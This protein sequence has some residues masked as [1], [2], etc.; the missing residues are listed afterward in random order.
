MFQIKR[1]ITDMDVA[2]HRRARLE[3][4]ANVPQCGQTAYRSG[5]THCFD[6][7][8]ELP[9]LVMQE[10]QRDMSGAPEK[11]A[12][13]QF[14]SIQEPFGTPYL[15]NSLF[16]RREYSAAARIYRRLVETT[17]EDQEMLAY[18]LTGL[19]ATLVAQNKL[20]EARE[21]MRNSV[22]AIIRSNG[23]RVK[24]VA[25]YLNV[26]ADI[27]M[28]EHRYR[29]AELLFKQTLRLRKKYLPGDN[30]NQID[31]LHDYALLL[32]ILDRFDEAEK[33]EKR[34]LNLLPIQHNLLFVPTASG[35]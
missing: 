20:D 27:Y 22:H 18:N 21:V 12:G 33:L 5:E 10:Y 16:R 2:E 34:A 35:F 24:T 17:T 3:S 28:K 29:A 32:R 25:R 7:P 14:F 1:S 9:H 31:I 23:T 26:L 15:A 8:R 30:E 4:A 19:A 6:I 11:R 13:S